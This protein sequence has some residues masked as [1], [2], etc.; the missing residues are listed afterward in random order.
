M[1]AEN[2][3]WLMMRS[4]FPENYCLSNSIPSQ[5]ASHITAQHSSDHSSWKQRRI[6]KF[7]NGCS[8]LAF[9]QMKVA[10]KSSQ[11]NNSFD[12]AARA[13]FRASTVASSKCLRDEQLINAIC[14]GL[15]LASS[16]AI[17]PGRGFASAV[18]FWY[19]LNK[20]LR[21]QKKAS[22]RRVKLFD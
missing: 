18:I 8:E 11:Q 14:S 15:F 16:A 6:I 7:R 20:Q 10:R 22:W 9:F 5:V 17:A 4:L 3:S 2:E 19:A 12:V 13:A 1:I 21:F